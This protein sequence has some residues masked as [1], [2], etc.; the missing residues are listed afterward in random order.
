MTERPIVL[1]EKAVRD[2]DDA[3]A[4]YVREAGEKIAVAFVDALEH[5]YRQ[6]ARYPASGSPRFAHELNLPDLRCWPLR[7][8]PY[9]AFYVDLNDEIDVW[10]VLHSARDIPAWLHDTP[11][12]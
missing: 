8:F 2:V 9:I 4:Y 5:A 1:R 3:I 6:I 7:R 12:D 11:I 10:R